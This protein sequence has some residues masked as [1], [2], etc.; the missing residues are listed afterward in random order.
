MGWMAEVRSLAGTREFFLL[1]NI[2]ASSGA[3]PGSST[4][5]TRAYFPGV[6]WQGHEAD[7]TPFSAEVKNGGAITPLPHMSS[8]SGA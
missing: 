6:R 3:Y 7:H 5:G 8:W 1:H 4:M 2:E